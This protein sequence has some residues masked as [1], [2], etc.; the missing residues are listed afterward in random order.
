[1]KTPKKIEDTLLERL[2][3]DLGLSENE[4]KVYLTL[5]EHGSLSVP[6][7]VRLTKINRTTIYSIAD[8]LISK[9]IVLEDVARKKAGFM[10]LPPENLLRI[11]DRIAAEAKQIRGKAERLILELNKLQ[12]KSAYPVPKVALIQ[13]GYIAEHMVS[14]AYRLAQDAVEFGQG[15]VYGFTDSTFLK[16]YWDIVDDF[17]EHQEIRKVDFHLIGER[18]NEELELLSRGYKH[19]KVKFWH[20]SID[21]NCSLWVYGSFVIMVITKQRPYYLLEIHDEVLAYN[22]RLV[23]EGLWGSIAE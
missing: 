21:F 16:T 8:Q 22:L 7:L 9:G 23:F 11:P 20:P 1:M 3:K 17:L 5:S 12:K 6:S 15:K 19:R 4:I 2:L 13:E 10:A 14:Q 18:S